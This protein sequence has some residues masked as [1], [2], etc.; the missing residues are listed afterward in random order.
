MEIE[1]FDIGNG[2][3]RVQFE[4]PVPTEEKHPHTGLTGYKMVVTEPW[5]DMRLRRITF[6]VF[7]NAPKQAIRSVIYDCWDHLSTDSSWGS[8]DEEKLRKEY[9]RSSFSYIVSEQTPEVE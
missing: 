9:H 8:I 2:W 1:V 3:E 4:Q 7:T 6:L 5:G